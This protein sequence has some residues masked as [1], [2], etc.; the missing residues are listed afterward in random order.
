MTEEP[1]LEGTPLL[2][3][4]GSGHIVEVDPPQTARRQQHHGTAHQVGH[5][6]PGH[7]AQ[8]RG[9]CLGCERA[10]EFGVLRRRDGIEARGCDAGRFARRE[11]DEQRL[12][13][14]GAGIG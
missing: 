13:S 8:A 3:E 10:A 6:F 12:E 7:P 4:L 2:A 1:D 11:V 9:V 5:A 14:G